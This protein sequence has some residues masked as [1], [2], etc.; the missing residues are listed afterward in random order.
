MDDVSLWLRSVDM[1]SHVD[2]FRAND[3][4]GA[5]LL[6]LTEKTLDFMKLNPLHTAKMLGKIDKLRGRSF[7][8]V[9]CFCCVLISLC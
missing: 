6:Q 4:D 5:T 3:I 1:D 7:F 9:L 2:A 8:L